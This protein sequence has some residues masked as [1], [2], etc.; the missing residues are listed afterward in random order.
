MTTTRTTTTEIDL[1][2]L[3]EDGHLDLEAI[4]RRAEWWRVE[5]IASYTAWVYGDDGDGPG[6]AWVSLW[7]AEAYGLTAWRWEDEDDAGSHDAGPITLDRDE[8]VRGG[9]AHAA[10]AGGAPDIDDLIQRIVGTGYFGGATSDDIRAVCEAATAYSQGYLLLPAGG[11]CGEPVGRL[12]TTH[13]YLQCRHVRIA[14]D[15]GSP[16]EAAYALLR[17]VEAEMDA[18]GDE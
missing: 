15:H 3:I 17:A 4:F 7:S 8:A 2:G 10:D 13:G 6:E 12:W 11:P 5:T 9:E 18:D 16:V 14:A 1:A